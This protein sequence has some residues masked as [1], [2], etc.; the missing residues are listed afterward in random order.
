LSSQRTDTHHQQPGTQFPTPPGQPLKPIPSK[1][2]LLP[3]ST[4]PGSQRISQA[5]LPRTQSTCEPFGG[6]FPRDRP[7]SRCPCLPGGTR[8]Y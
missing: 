4:R 3:F 7:P 2:P 5:I 1:S 8:K 6:L